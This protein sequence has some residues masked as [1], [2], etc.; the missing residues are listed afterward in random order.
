ME[1]REFEIEL[2]SEDSTAG[3]LVAYEMVY[4]CLLQRYCEGCERFECFSI[5]ESING[6]AGRKRLFNTGSENGRCE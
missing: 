2:L 3:R 5:F 6:G 4:R 1:I